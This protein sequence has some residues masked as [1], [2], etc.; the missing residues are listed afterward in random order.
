MGTDSGFR[1]TRL[2]RLARLPRITMMSTEWQ[3]PLRSGCPRPRVPL[4]S[5]TPPPTASSPISSATDVPIRI[6]TR[7]SALALWQAQAVKSWLQEL[8]PERT[9][10]I[11]IISSDGD[12][13]KASPLTQIGGRGVF[14]SALQHALLV[15]EIDMAVHTTKD[16]P[17]ETP[18]GLAIA[19]FPDRDNPLDVLVSRHGVGLAD[20][21]ANPVI[22]TSSRRRAVLIRA[23]R[24][25]AEIV[26]LRGNID[27][28]LRKSRTEQYDAIVL[29]AA[30]LI[31]MD[32]ESEITEFLNLEQVTPAPG[33][34]VLAVE[35]RAEPDPVY[36]LVHAIDDPDVRLA[37]EMERA[38]LRGVGGG[39]T[40]PIGAHARLHGEGAAR[41]VE[42]HAMLASDDG[43]HIAR[44]REVFPIDRAFDGAVAVAADLLREIMPGWSGVPI[45]ASSIDTDIPSGVRVA[46]TGSPDVADAQV[47]QLI[48]AGAE[49]VLLPTVRIA[50][51]SDPAALDDAIARAVAG[52]VAWV[53][54][55]SANAVAPIA[56]RLGG[57]RQLRAK[58]AAVG[59][60]TAEALSNVGIAV[61]VV[62]SHGSAV[63][64]LEALA[65]EPLD[66]VRVLLPSSN[67]ARPTLPEGLR[68]RGAIV[69]TVVAYETVP[70]T[71]LD[72]E[73]RASLEARPVDAI[74]FSSPSAVTGFAQL[75]D[76]DRAL[77]ADAAAIAI[78]ETTAEAVRTAGLT[79]AA[80]ATSPTPIGMV[81]ALSTYLR[82]S[83]IS[84][85]PVS[86][87]ERT[88]A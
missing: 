4:V 74:F 16:L 68:E 32:W 85:D 29:A 9:F 61:D 66:G 88:Q 82:T 70:L 19:A 39:C 3:V 79:V 64:L 12:R 18:E 30:G 42:L 2:I 36:A 15:G 44:V 80:I 5:H 50:P 87:D 65:D 13:D 55:T 67:L 14:A 53:M 59:E 54:F 26:D 46:V 1:R 63:G 10:E 21:P 51:A 34:G 84:S 40:N 47:A 28:R 60:R 73:T 8:H 25:D 23:L 24:P 52:E 69:E 17:S 20:L 75:P 56:E 27:T 45:A 76:A 57:D 33:Q 83:R 81:Q 7:G 71:T 31:R 78:G 11:A 48:A 6:G 43:T 41:E 62:A 35:T 58:V 72:A 38:F 86:D 37:V 22:G 77:L 49:A